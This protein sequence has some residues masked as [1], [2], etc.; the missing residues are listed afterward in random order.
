MSVKSYIITTLSI[1]GSLYLYAQEPVVEA[2]IPGLE[3][4]KEYMSLLRQ[5]AVLQVREDSVLHIINAR[6]LALRKDPSLTKSYTSEI[7]KLESAIFDIRNAKG[8][9]IDKINTIE[10]EWVFASLDAGVQIDPTQQEEKISDTPD[11]L[12]VRNLVDNLYFKEHLPEADY[13]AL[14]QAQG[15]ELEA[16]EYV[17]N[18]FLN[19]NTLTELVAAYD[20]A[21]TQEEAVEIQGRY[22][23]LDSLNLTL[24]HSL[25][26][27]WNYIYDNK[28][29]AYG[30]ILDELDKD[31]M[32]SQ[33]EEESQAALRKASALRGE[34]MSDEVVDYFMRKKQMVGHEKRVADLLDLKSASDSLGGVI[35]QLDAVNFCLPRQEIRERNFIVYDSIEISRT[36]KYSYQNPIPECVVYP[37]GTVYRILLGTYNTKRAVSTFR[38][39]YPL[40]YLINEDKKWCYY[41]GGFATYQEAEEAQAF[42]KKHGFLRPEIVMWRDG[43]MTNISRDGEAAQLTYRVEI[44]GTSSLSEELKAVIGELAPSCDVSRVGQDLFVISS[45]SDC[46]EA[47]KLAAA[48]QNAASDLEIKVK[49][50]SNQ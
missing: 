21:Q 20:N 6:R 18:M 7:L 40:S 30:Y 37:K 5:D 38:G 27:A 43:E 3:N 28:N 16:V 24:A 19:Y 48:L 10:Q 1:L 29:Y 50:V 8:R 22:K 15:K 25:A 35:K 39:A 44:N 47:D 9:L 33:Q 4:N 42:L 36:P 12:K 34:T 26:E 2:R 13:T 23:S 11:S 41:T 17:N 46:A 32:L 49:E 45:F 31:D 14:Q